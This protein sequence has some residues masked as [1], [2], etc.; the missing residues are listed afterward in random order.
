MS[1][2]IASSIVAPDPGLPAIAPSA[3]S[4]SQAH[5]AS[6]ADLIEANDLPGEGRGEDD[7][8]GGAVQVGG[9]QRLAEDNLAGDVRIAAGGDGEDR[10]GFAVFESGD[11]T[12]TVAVMAH[13]T[14]G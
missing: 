7:G 11:G 5:D 13:E 6:A 3:S 4:S 10:G 2:A 1:S 14:P 8:V 12:E 9:G